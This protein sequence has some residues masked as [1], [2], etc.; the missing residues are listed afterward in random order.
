MT[1]YASPQLRF[2]EYFVLF[3]KIM[4]R[5]FFILLASS[6]IVWVLGK[7]CT[8]PEDCGSVD[9]WIC[10]KRQC[11]EFKQINDTCEISEQCYSNLVCVDEQCK[12]ENGYRF[13]TKCIETEETKEERKRQAREKSSLKTILS[14][15]GI[16]AGVITF[17]VILIIRYRIKKNK[18][19]L[20]ERRK[21]VITFVDHSDL[22]R[23]SI[24]CIPMTTKNEYTERF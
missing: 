13:E 7:T 6:S 14:V 1:E 2:L 20:Q 22:S 18:A 5:L 9:E 21:S 8:E 23:D 17:L 10:H 3:D 12:C 16:I 11:Y 15:V 4:D 19:K 24:I